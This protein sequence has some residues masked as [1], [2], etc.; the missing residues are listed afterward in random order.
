MDIESDETV[1]RAMN[2]INAGEAG[3]T[4]VQGEGAAQ[5]NQPK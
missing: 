3:A 2:K 4:V 1:K 5:I